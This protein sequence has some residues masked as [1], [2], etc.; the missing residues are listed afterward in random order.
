MS[1]QRDRRPGGCLLLSSEE[2][3]A[4]WLSFEQKALGVTRRSGVAGA[5]GD[6]YNEKHERSVASCRELVNGRETWQADLR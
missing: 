4:C 2:G 6:T 3:D 1:E 5:G